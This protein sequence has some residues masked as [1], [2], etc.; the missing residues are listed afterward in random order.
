MADGQQDFYNYYSGSYTQIA[1]V[2]DTVLSYETA[3]K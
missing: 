1:S 3:G 2:N